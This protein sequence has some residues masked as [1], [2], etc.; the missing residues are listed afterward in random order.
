MD[1]SRRIGANIIMLDSSV[2]C[3]RALWNFRR[4]NSRFT[5]GAFDKGRGINRG[6]FNL[7]KCFVL[8]C[9]KNFDSRRDARG[10]R[11]KR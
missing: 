9:V 1:M 2:V 3:V 4:K 8:G 10:Q 7:G 11:E 6:Q 5:W